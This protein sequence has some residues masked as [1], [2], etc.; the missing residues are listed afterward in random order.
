MA[1]ICK[2]NMAARYHMLMHGGGYLVLYE[3]HKLVVCQCSC[4][5]QEVYIASALSCCT[6]LYGQAINFSV[7]GA[8][9]AAS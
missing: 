6:N 3:Y 5:C 2:T 7:E 4:F 9:L 8:A 1:A